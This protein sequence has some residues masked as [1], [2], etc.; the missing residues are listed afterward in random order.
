MPVRK[1]NINLNINQLFKYKSVRIGLV[2]LII[3]TVLSVAIILASGWHVKTDNFQLNKDPLL[4]DAKQ[5]QR[6]R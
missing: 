2:I 4:K 6:K 3:G 1:A 5:L